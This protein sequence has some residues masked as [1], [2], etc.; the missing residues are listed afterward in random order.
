M[1]HAGRPGLEPGGAARGDVRLQVGDGARGE[2]LPQ[3]L[4]VAALLRLD[5]LRP[6]PGDTLDERAQPPA[7]TL[8][9][10]ARLVLRVV[11]P[12]RQGRVDQHAPFHRLG[13][14]HRAALAEPE[15][16]QLA[17]GRR[18][19]PFQVLLDAVEQA[20]R[21][22]AQLF[23]LVGIQRAEVD[24]VDFVHVFLLAVSTDRLKRC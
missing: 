23:E 22:G 7:R 9:V 15:R 8:R 10:A 13:V 3:P 4:L 11:E 18:V 17:P 16:L 24:A 6:V 12:V 21:R 1:P 5:A 20:Q 19:P 14:E 2:V